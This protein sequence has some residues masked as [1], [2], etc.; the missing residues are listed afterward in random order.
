MKPTSSNATSGT[1][2]FEMSIRGTVDFQGV[3]EPVSDA[4]VY[5]RLQETGRAD[6]K[7]TTVAE[8]VINHV[9][10]APEGHP[11]SFTLPIPPDENGRYVVRVH[12]DVTGDGKV[13][14]GDYVST[15]SYPVDMN[16]ELSGLA[17]VAKRV[18]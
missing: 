6:A 11:I 12:A 2:P 1:H 17:I 14:Q 10:I 3:K 5:V 18:G 9:D 7:A 15:Q 4:T 16:A 8:Q 13:S